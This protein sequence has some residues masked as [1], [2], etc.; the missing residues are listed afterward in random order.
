MLAKIGFDSAETEPY[1]IYCITPFFDFD[2]SPKFEPRY[3]LRRR[4]GGD[5][6]H[7]R[8]FNVN[9]WFQK[10]SNP[11]GNNNRAGWFQQPLLTGSLE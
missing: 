5:T 2:R 4:A 1:K 8:V 11:G 3:D 7:S 9:G 10:P 6:E